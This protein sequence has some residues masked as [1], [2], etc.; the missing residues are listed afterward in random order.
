M[1]DYLYV[2]NRTSTTE[3]RRGTETGGKTLSEDTKGTKR[4]LPLPRLEFASSPSLSPRKLSGFSPCL[5]PPPCLRGERTSAS[6]ACK[7][8][9]RCHQLPEAVDVRGLRS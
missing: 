1:R 4:T 7:R 2:N 5:R 3:T 8:S 6:A 9:C